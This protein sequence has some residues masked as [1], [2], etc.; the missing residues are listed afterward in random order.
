MNRT[1][2]ARQ[3]NLGLENLEGRLA[4]SSMMSHPAASHPAA[5]TPAAQQPPHGPRG[6]YQGPYA[7]YQGPYNNPTY[8]M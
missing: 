4:P 6:T 3:F 1:R 2:A 8:V 7:G 5:V